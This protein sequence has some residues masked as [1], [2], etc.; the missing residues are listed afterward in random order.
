[1]YRLLQGFRV[2]EG[3]SFIAAPSC[4]LHLAQLGAEV[5][6]F[7]MIGGGPDYRRWPLAPGG[8]SLYWEGLNKGKKSIAIDLARPDGRELAAR[9]VAAPGEGGGMFVTNFPVDGFLAYDRLRALRADLILLRVMGRADGGT[10]VDYTVNSAYGVPMMTGPAAL[11]DV[12]VN[13]VLPAW[14]LLAGAYGAFALMAAERHRRISGNGQE[15]TL[16]LD[17]LAIASLGHL[18]QIAETALSGSDRPRLGNDLFGAFGRD[19]VTAD[20]HRLMIVAITA[21]QWKAL[22]SALGIETEIAGLERS[23]DVSFG[24]DEGKRFEH[25]NRINPIVEKAVA[26]RT[27]GDLAAAFEAARVCW[28]PYRTLAGALAEDPLLT[29]SNPL[30]AEITHPSGESYLT[31][32]A[33]AGFGGS[34]REVPVRA[35]MLGEHTDEI[36]A[37]LL[38]MSS[39]EIGTLHDRGI[40]AGAEDSR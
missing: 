21:Q 31:P 3:A 2:V 9:L 30:L 28:G 11:G 38:G 36:L 18:G 22:I 32:G 23:A 4:G 40:V 24:R 29:T 14:D 37:D 17:N 19:F 1:M 33:T 20:G 25:R 5:I 34:N 15:I 6:R 35:P 13:H 10:A 39:G 7:D 16:P 27:R 8:D 26:A 12:P